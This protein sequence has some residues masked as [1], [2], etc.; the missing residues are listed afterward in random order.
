MLFVQKC[1][2]APFEAERKNIFLQLMIWS[3]TNERTN[4]WTSETKQNLPEF[5]LSN[6]G[7]KKQKAGLETF[8]QKFSRERKTRKIEIKTST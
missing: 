5:F 7:G 4:K 1:T 3:A 6:L 2:T 8:H